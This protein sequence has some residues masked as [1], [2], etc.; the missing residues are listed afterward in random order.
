MTTFLYRCPTTG[1]N[2]QGWIAEDVA[3]GTVRKDTYFSIDCLAC[4]QAHLVNPSTGHVAGSTTSS[5]P[6]R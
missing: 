1:M 4:K 5:S 3:A 2:V 6:K